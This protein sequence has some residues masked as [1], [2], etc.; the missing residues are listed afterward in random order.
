[1]A[2]RPDPLPVLLGTAALLLSACGGADDKSSSKDG[3][4]GAQTAASVATAAAGAATGLVSTAGLPAFVE[5]YEGGT[6]VMHMQ[7]SERD[8]RGGLFSYTVDAPLEQV[9]AFHRQSSEK[10]GFLISTEMAAQDSLTFGG[11]NKDETMQLL[12]TISR[13]EDGISVSLTY[14]LPKG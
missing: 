11:R 4:T 3:M 8:T 12:A 1:M 13:A 5:M 7:T 6:P 9:V 2:H 14:S 10:A